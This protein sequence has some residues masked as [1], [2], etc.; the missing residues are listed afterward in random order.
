[1]MSESEYPPAF[2][3][4]PSSFRDPSGFIFSFNGELYRQVN[5][6]FREHFDFFISSGLYKT[7]VEKKLLIPHEEITGDFGTAPERYKILKPEKIHCISY[8]Y[9]WCFDMLKDAAL[10]TLQ[11]AKESLH[12]GMFLKDATPYNIQWHKDRLIFIDSLSF[13]K[14]DEGKPWIAYR[15]FCEYFLGPLLLMHYRQTSLH[16][17]QLAYPAGIPLQ[18]TTKLLPWK[19]RLSI[20]T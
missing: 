13:E 9:E 4:H 14:Y 6:S 18:I 7:V 8:P 11:L 16:E 1:M 19:S 15:Q 12:Y 3:I 5:H 2:Q 20:L 17:L 10:L